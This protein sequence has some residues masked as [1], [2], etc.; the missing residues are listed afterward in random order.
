MTD[1]ARPSDH[2]GRPAAKAVIPAA[3]LGTRFLPATKATPKEMLPVVDK[4]A[5]PVRRRGGGGRRA[6][7]RP[8]DHRT[9][10][11]LLEDHFDRM[12][13]LEDALEAKG[14]NEQ[15]R[16]CGRQTELATSTT[17]ARATAKGLGHA[18]LRAAQHVG[19]E[20]FAV[21]LGDDLIDERDP[22][23]DA[24]CSRCSPSSAARRRADGGPTR[25]DPPV[26]LCGRRGRPTT[27]TS[28]ASSRWSRS[29]A[30]EAPSN[31]PSSAATCWRARS[32]RCSRTP[33]PGRAA[34]SSSPTRCATLRGRRQSGAR[35]DLPRTPLRH[36]R[37]A[38]VPPRGGPGRVPPRRPRPR[39][40][41]MAVR[42]RRGRLRRSARTM[43][44]G[45]P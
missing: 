39:F 34:R 23:L 27:P 11:E 41:R 33:N 6:H 1:P 18:V 15:L 12:L 26:R 32:S 38:V 29:P 16:R 42:L 44:A 45:N 7:R 35:R 31:L 9:Q 4:P 10:Q 40:P 2:P 8:P 20:P 24:R 30:D 36:R 13:E 21:L 28:S 37:P 43:S 19:N 5:H 17:C 22:L 3:G 14:N 25:P